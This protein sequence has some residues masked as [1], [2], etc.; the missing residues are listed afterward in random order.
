VAATVTGIFG[1]PGGQEPSDTL[2]SNGLL[3]ASRNQL[4]VCVHAAAGASFGAD[5]ARTRVQAALTDVIRDP[6]WS[7]DAKTGLPVVDIGCPSEPYLLQPGVSY[8][9]KPIGDPSVQ[10]VET[11]SPYRVFVFVLPPAE[12]SRIFGD[13]GSSIRVEPQEFLCEGDVCAEVTTGLYLSP[14]E[15]ADPDF[16]EGWPRKT[17]GLEPLVP[18]EKLPVDPGQ[19]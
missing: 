16:L 17:L 14:E 6:L 2:V 9:G 13:T 11:A 7:G 5:E 10:A 1:L 15:L 19:R 4:A 18:E 12:L 8:G 3:A